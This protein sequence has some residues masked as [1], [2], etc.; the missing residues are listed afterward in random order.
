MGAE[1]ERVTSS[2]YDSDRLCQTRAVCG[3]GIA[4]DV[5]A[6]D[7]DYCT[8][9]DN[10][11]MNCYQDSDCPVIRAEDEERRARAD[12]AEGR[13]GRDAPP[14]DG[15]AEVEDAGVI[16]PRRREAPGEGPAVGG[17]CERGE[18]PKKVDLGT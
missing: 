9:P 18:V 13:G 14:G 16:H 2:Q 12:I 11:A 7:D 1:E 6:G 8:H 17:G 3:Y 10:D 4:G 5:D 15:G